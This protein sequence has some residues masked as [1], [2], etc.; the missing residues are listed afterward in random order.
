MDALGI[1]VPGLLSQLINFLILLGLLYM[2][3][4]RPIIRMLDQRSLR[5]KESLEQAEM[6][7]QQAQQAQADFQVQIEQARREGQEIVAQA[8]KIG[9]QMKEEARQEARTQAEQILTRAR[10]EIEAERDQAISE[11][12]KEFADLTVAAAGRVINRSLD[13]SAHMDLIDEVLTESST[14]RGGG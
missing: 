6:V 9:E 8:T 10:S 4:Y 3:L 11:L 13:K 5:I 2:F 7:R 14:F 1:N 12:R